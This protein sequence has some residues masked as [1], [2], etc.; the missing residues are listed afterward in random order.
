MEKG[1]LYWITGLAGAGKTTIGN[2]LYEY[3]RSQ[4]DN[5][6]I[7]DGDIIREIYRSSDYSNEGRKKLAET[8]MRL[9][10]ML[11]E[12]GIDVVICI[13]AMYNDC[14]MWNRNNISNYKEIYIKV[15]MEE[16]IRRDQ[17]QLYSKAMRGEIENVMG[18][19]I[20]F[21]EPQTPDLIINN[22]GQDSPE[23]ILQYI[24]KE[25]NI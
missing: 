12:Q 19:D 18:I 13:I 17:K 16:L 9:C 4:K 24:V 15:D 10:R 7:I 5:V 6:V 20:P 25:L 8:S 3:L 2:L 14:R 23:E 1:T 11:T 22:N 21:E